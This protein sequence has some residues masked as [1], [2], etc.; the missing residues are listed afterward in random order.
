M[1]HR[2]W[3]AAA[4]EACFNHLTDVAFRPSYLICQQLLL[5]VS[6]DSIAYQQ[7]CQ[8][9]VVEERG[10][11]LI[12]TGFPLSENLVRDQD[13]LESQNLFFSVQHV[14]AT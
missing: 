6:L 8:F 2:S 14:I 12:P 9:V 11:N 3:S 1:I 5:A 13:G 10:K 7:V 4:D